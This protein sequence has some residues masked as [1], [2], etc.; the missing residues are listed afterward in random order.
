MKTKI[1]LFILPF[2]LLLILVFLYT[3]TSVRPHRMFAMELNTQDGVFNSNIEQHIDTNLVLVNIGNLPRKQ[4][5]VLID[6]IGNATPKAMAI[7]VCFDKTKTTPNDH[8]LV[9]VLQK[10]QHKIVLHNS[11]NEGCI[12]YE[13]VATRVS[14]VKTNEA[15]FRYWNPTKASLERS[16]IQKFRPQQIKKLGYLPNPLL[17]NYQIGFNSILLRDGQDLLDNYFQP[18]VFRNKIVYL[19][20]LGDT[21]PADIQ[22]LSPYGYPLLASLNVLHNILNDKH[23]QEVNHWLGVAVTLVLVLFNM[24]LAR[25]LRQTPSVIYFTLA[26]IFSYFTIFASIAIMF[27]WHLSYGL[28]VY[29]SYTWAWAL[30]GYLV[31]WV[32]RR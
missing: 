27:Y 17:I 10:H 26:I 15:Y 32:W 2:S 31:V 4:L 21:L 9:Q 30:G 25:F 5:T 12:R 23:L 8:L 20:Y 28:V 7:F 22:S 29:L 13:G 6:S 18:E 1:K 24:L 11:P 14:A 3:F 16:L 19:G